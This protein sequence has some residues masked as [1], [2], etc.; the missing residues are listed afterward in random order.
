MQH[1]PRRIV[2]FGP[3]PKFK[4]GISDY[5]TALA[6]ALD[7]LEHT[8]V[9]IVSWTQQYPA[10]IPREF[11]DKK[12]KTDFISGTDIKVHYLTNY[13]NPF[14]WFATADFIAKLQPD[15]VV[16]QWAI[17]IQGLPLRWIASQIHRKSNAEIIFDLHF[18][19]QKEGSIIDN[20]FSKMALKQADTYIAHAY[21]TV[22]E[23]KT[24]L[25][26]QKY[27]VNETGLRDHNA[28]TVIKLFHPVYDLFKE[29]PE[30]DVAA[31]KEKMGLKKH[32]FLF[33]GFIRKY[34]GLH[35]A[36]EAF[37]KVAARRDDISF[38]ICGES[39]WK[40]LPDTLM[41]RL[42]KWIFGLLKKI[43][44]N[45]K[46]DESDY[47]PLALIDD[48]KLHNSV[49]TVNEFIANEE[50]H[51]YFQTC[52]AVV[53]FY[54]YATPSGIESL[55]YNFKKPILATKVGHFPETI[56]DGFNGYLAE[57][58]DTDSMAEVMMKY[59]D[60]PLPAENVVQKTREM[61]WE[62]YARAILNV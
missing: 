6:L 17:A 15:M 54:E 36:I 25:P 59:L 9:H 14:T 43:L 26:A 57:A 22:D 61:S 50:V 27:A 1:N 62:K 56:E 53:L 21:K 8:E 34:K 39:F 44:L 58:G 42:K 7:K 45:K 32:V 28:K 37:S 20:W 38:L 35:Y 10:I 23:L 51:Q 55:S 48:F 2:C 30:F 16:F 60:H 4:G 29:K 31:F 11:I 33:F 3:G 24:L 41:T 5:N 19:I 46:E 40:T 12:S 47:N 52:D 13:N 18:V 49:V